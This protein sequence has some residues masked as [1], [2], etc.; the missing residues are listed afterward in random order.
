MG[1]IYKVVPDDTFI[2]IAQQI[3]RKLAALPTVAL[4]N[5]KKALNQSFYNTVEQQLSLESKLQI[6]SAATADYAEGVAAF[7]EKRTPVFKGK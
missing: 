4:A 5:T 1:M 3:A 7:I 2:E 6:E